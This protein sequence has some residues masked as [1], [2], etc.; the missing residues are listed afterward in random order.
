MGLTEKLQGIFQNVVAKTSVH[1]Y[2][3]RKHLAAFSQ[4]LEH[5]SLVLDVGSG[6]SPYRSVFSHFGKYVALDIKRGGNVDLVADICSL[7]IRSDA[8]EV[9]ICTEVLEHV[10]DT[11]RAVEELNRVLRTGGYLILTTP[12]LIGVHEAIDFF[13]FTELA[14]RSLLSRYGFEIL[15]IRKRGG[16]FSSLGAMLTQL[17]YQVLGPYGKGPYGKSAIVPQYLKY[18]LLFSIYLL[19]IPTTSIFIALDVLDRG[20]NFTLGYSVLCSKKRDWQN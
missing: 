13:R 5:D 12:L 1:A 19:L 11:N 3:L 18:G 7:P 17:P 16:I 15:E 2:Y 9:I 10:E 14:L 8:V 6:E 20:K 4:R